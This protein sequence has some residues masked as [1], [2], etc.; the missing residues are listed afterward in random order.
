MIDHIICPWYY[1][2]EFELKK[3]RV[4]SCM[5]LSNEGGLILVIFVQYI[6]IVNFLNHIHKYWTICFTTQIY[7]SEQSAQ[8]TMYDG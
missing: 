2:I 3:G 5:G 7:V 1:T 6:L 4:E 8:L